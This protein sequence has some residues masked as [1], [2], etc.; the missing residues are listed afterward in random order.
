MRTADCPVC[1]AHVKRLITLAP[2]LTDKG[3]S[4]VV[5]VPE[6]EAERQVAQ[7]LHTPFPVVQGVTAHASIGLQRRLFL[8]QQSGTVIHDAARLVTH[9]R[10][11]TLP[12]GSF[13]ED[14]VL[15]LLK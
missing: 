9:V 2:R 5:V 6:G 10:A 4:V 3:L 15:E 7:S 11:A 14:A 8:V 13:D 1:R 12:G